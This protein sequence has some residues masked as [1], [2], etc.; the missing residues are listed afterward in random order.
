MSRIAYPLKFVCLFATVP[1]LMLTACQPAASPDKRAAIEHTVRALDAQWSKAA[2][3]HD[4]SA[5]VSYYADNAQL[6]PPD[7]PLAATAQTRRTSWANFLATV[8]TISWEVKKAEVARSED[9]VYVTGSWT[10]TP[11]GSHDPKTAAYGKFLEVWKLQLDGQWKC[12]ADIYNAD[13]P[14][15]PTK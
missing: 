4:V 10:I 11:K 12:V 9:L 1:L 14:A 7:E 13:A 5:T 15:V 2:G 8:E 3:A 6:L